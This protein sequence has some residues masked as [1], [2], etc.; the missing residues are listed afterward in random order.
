M[1]MGI[2]RR[3]RGR[4]PGPR[5]TRAVILAAIATVV[6]GGSVAAVEVTLHVAGGEPVR[7]GGAEPVRN[8]RPHDLLGEGTAAFDNTLGVRSLAGFADTYA[9]LLC[10]GGDVPR[11]A[12]ATRCRIHLDGAGDQVRRLSRP[13]L[14][15]AEMDARR[16]SAG[17]LLDVDD[18][19]A[20]ASIRPARILGFDPA[21]YALAPGVPAFGIGA[22]KTRR[23]RP[24]TRVNRYSASYEEKPPE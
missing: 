19:P 13:G 7:E 24:S 17:L 23:R 12:D 1:T 9:A 20:G 5:A 14:E 16:R 21:A 6:G 8:G 4:Q 22:A 3:D 11:N 15:D 18:A 10:T 2:V